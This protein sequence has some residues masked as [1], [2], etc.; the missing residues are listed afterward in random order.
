MILA[1]D[2]AFR[3]GGITWGHLVQGTVRAG[4]VVVVDVLGEDAF[5]LARTVDQEFV[6]ALAPT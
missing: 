4:G 2:G 5:G 1:L 3:F 6:E